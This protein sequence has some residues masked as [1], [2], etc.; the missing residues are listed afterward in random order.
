MQMMVIQC[1]DVRYV[2]SSLSDTMI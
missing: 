1:V 2:V